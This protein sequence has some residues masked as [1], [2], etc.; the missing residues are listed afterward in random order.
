MRSWL[1]LVNRAKSLI[2]LYRIEYLVDFVKLRVH[3]LIL[4]NTLA[5]ILQD[6]LLLTC[7]Y[8]ALISHVEDRF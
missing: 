5:L 2:S 3:A 7:N 4:Q 6:A 8:C 1:L